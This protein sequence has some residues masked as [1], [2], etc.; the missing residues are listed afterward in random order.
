MGYFRHHAIL[1][2]GWG[3]HVVGAHIAARAIFALYE[4][5]APVTAL[6]REVVNGYQSFAVLPDGSKEG[7]DESDQGDAARDKLI[8][9]LREDNYCS[10]AEVQYGD[11][12][13]D[14]KVL[15]HDHDE[16][17]TLLD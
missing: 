9:W 7:W 4:S 5:V 13:Y 14:N 12:E 17:R 15:R 10:W 6:T 1:V 16:E 3:Q 8:A 2:T 11:E